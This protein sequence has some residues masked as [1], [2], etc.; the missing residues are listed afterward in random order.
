MQ[1][2]SDEK[3][4]YENAQVQMRDFLTKWEYTGKQSGCLRPLVRLGLH[5][6]AEVHEEPTHG[7]RYQGTGGICRGMGL[8]LTG[9]LSAF[10]CMSNEAQLTGGART[11]CL[12]P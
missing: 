9:C 2:L 3:R 11:P 4:D 12:L 7:R 6:F 8:T 10:S 1:H 5:H